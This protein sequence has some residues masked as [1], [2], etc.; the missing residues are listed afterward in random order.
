[1]TWAESAMSAYRL[2]PVA[3]FETS[4]G[5]II[6]NSFHKFQVEQNIKTRDI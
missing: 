5:Q 4:E 6:Y 1:M 3:L 2:L